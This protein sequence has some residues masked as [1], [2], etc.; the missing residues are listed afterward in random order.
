MQ[1]R[2]D[3][4]GKIAVIGQGGC[5]KTFMVHQLANVL[6]GE[7]KYSWDEEVQMAGTFSVTPY[8]MEFSDNFWVF[9]DNP[10]QS[11]LRNK[12][13]STAIRGFNY[14]GLIIV[15]DALCWNFRNIGI[16]QA[17]EIRQELDVK[18]IPVCIIVSKKDI[19][20]TFTNQKGKKLIDFI[21][22]LLSKTASS[23][24]EKGNIAFKNR[25]TK[26]DD[27]FTNKTDLGMISF[28]SLEQILVNELDKYIQ[29]FSIPGLS[30]MNIRLFIRSLLLGYC[31]SVKG[32]VDL[33]KYPEFAGLEDKHL[34]NRLNYHRPTAYE[35]ETPWHTL[36]YDERFVES[37]QLA[38]PP[39]FLDLFTTE[40][41]KEIILSKVLVDDRKLEF[42]INGVKKLGKR[43]DWEVISYCYGD[44]VTSAGLQIIGNTITEFL[45]EIHN[46]KQKIFAAQSME[47]TIDQLNLDQF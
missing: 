24:L 47:E 35:T 15:A 13:L 11:S 41:V 9:N 10:G 12:R 36:R 42:F 43:I 17:E 37:E 45:T 29:Q 40:Y 46:R 38:E 3:Y 5:G 2:K 25:V 6:A 20:D 1:Q 28:T 39:I 16:Y 19:R 4:L 14:A 44:S 7:E 18:N 21:A 33:E 27:S 34:K 30:P 26:I 32:V 23:S 22:E 31:E 8:K